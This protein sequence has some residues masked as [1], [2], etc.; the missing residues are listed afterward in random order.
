MRGYLLRRLIQAPLVLWLV[1]TISFFLMRF[2]PGGP[3]DFERAPPP[4]VEQ[5]LREQYRLDDPLAV[6]YGRFLVDLLRGDLGPSFK[7]PGRSV[8]EIIADR[9]PPTLLLG[10]LTLVISIVAGVALGL[11]SAQRH[12]SLWDYGA[13]TIALF[14]L[15][16]PAFVV[17]P[18]LLLLLQ[19]HLGWVEP[20]GESGPSL[21]YVTLAAGTL[22]LPFAARIAR[23]TRAGMLEIVH[24][25]FV[26]TARAKGMSELTIVLKHTLRGT[27]LP[28]IG[29]LGPAVAAI[30]TGSLVVETIFQLKGLGFEFVYAAFNRDYTLVMGTVITYASLLVVAN[31]LVDCLYGLLDPRVRYD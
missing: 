23:L 21:I 15:S 29:F 1:V 9:L 13:M 7:Y 28:V 3:F 14:G 6:Q 20:P 5:A 10:G 18:L 11:I 8:N 25:D 12:N 26:R 19:T 2:A 31:I 16:V 27:L 4:E 24:Q 30:L 17:G 22:A